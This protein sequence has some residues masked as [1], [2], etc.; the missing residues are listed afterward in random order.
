MPAITTS[1][2]NPQQWMPTQQI[3]DDRS[4]WSFE[5]P[6]L[7]KKTVAVDVGD[8][9]L[10]ED[11]QRN[12][13][14]NSQD[15]V[16]RKLQLLHSEWTE[17]KRRESLTVEEVDQVSG[18]SSASPMATVAEEVATAAVNDRRVADLQHQLDELQL[19]TTNLT[20][21]IQHKDAMIHQLNN[22][23]KILRR[24]NDQLIG[25]QQALVAELESYQ[26]M[27][28]HQASVDD[29]IFTP[30]VHRKLVDE[31]RLLREENLRGKALCGQMLAELQA[32]HS[33]SS[34]SAV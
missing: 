1:S 17:V 25:E 33:S 26:Q 23:V 6:E 16:Q 31:V 13:A 11:D 29:A 30:E 27:F 28:E 21:L 3:D 32:L 5:S 12:T 7:K 8:D 10:Y 20:E 18:S 14:N 19:T 15:I 22:D 24:E 2:E 4:V 9:E 34:S